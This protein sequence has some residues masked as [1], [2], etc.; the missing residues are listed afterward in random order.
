MS[1]GASE[2]DKKVFPER[3]VNANI[4]RTEGNGSDLLV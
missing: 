4:P 1:V 3:I 2:N